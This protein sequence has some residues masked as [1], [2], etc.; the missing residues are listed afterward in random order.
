MKWAAAVFGLGA[1]GAALVA[2]ATLLYATHHRE[3][4]ATYYRYRE[5]DDGVLPWDP[6]TVVR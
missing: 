2:A 1:V 5:D 3:Y 4:P 6:R